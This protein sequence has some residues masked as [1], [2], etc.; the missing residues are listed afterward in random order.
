[1]PMPAQDRMKR[2]PLAALLILL[3]LVLGSASTA[4]A[5]NDLRGPAARPGSSRHAAALLPSLTRNTP[6][7]EALGD[8][9]A[10]S[11][12]PPSAPGIVTQALWA[13]PLPEA[14]SAAW[15]AVPQPA[16]ASYRARAPP[17]S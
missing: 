16:A 8:G 10:G 2:G 15:N 13:R 5:G 1:V 4:A 9:G 3:S 6:D 17:A 12:L 7:D 11:P 14:A